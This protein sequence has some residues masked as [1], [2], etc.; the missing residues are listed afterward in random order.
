[1]CTLV[2]FSLISGL[3]VIIIGARVTVTSIMLFLFWYERQ[4]IL[5]DNVYLLERVMRFRWDHT[6]ES[7]SVIEVIDGHS[8][9][10]YIRLR[11]DWG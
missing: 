7:A 2:L 9:V 5:A 1:M 11:Q 10:L 8:D 4:F 6:L 3:N